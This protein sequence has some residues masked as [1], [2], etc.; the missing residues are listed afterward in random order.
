VFRGRT[1]QTID[2]KGRITLP[3]KYREILQKKYDNTLVVS[4]FDHFL[5][6][7]PTEEWI[8]MEEKIKQLPSGDSQAR[9]FK[10]FII[11]GA[12]ECSV[13]KQGRILIPPSL[14]TYAQLDREIVAAGQIDH[15]EI[16][17]RDRFYENIEFEAGEELME[18]I[19]ELGL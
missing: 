7:Y 2:I 15:F 13:D 18:S 6:A 17:N 11:S 19:D 8:K 14:K 16:W 9:A 10:R 4:N 12:T 5:I 3:V 1:D